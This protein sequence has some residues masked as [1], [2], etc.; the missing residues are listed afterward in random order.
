MPYNVTIQVCPEQ[1]HD[2]MAVN[3]SSGI[4]IAICHVDNL[5]AKW[6]LDTYWSNR[7]YLKISPNW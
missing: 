1:C 2:E 5:C 4:I 7:I 3:N 6:S